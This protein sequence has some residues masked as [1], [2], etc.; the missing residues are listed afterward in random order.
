MMFPT[1]GLSGACLT[2]AFFALSHGK[3]YYLAP[4]YPMLLAAGAVCLGSVRSSSWKNLALAVVVV[5]GLLAAPITMPVRSP[6]K[7]TVYLD[8]LPFD[9]PRS[10]VSHRSAALPQYYADQFGWTE[11]AELVG[12]E[13]A[14]LPQ[15]D[16]QQCGIFAQNYGEAGALDFLGRRFHLPPVLSGHQSYFLW[17]AHNYSGKCLLVVGERREARLRELFE[18]VEFV[19][20]R[21]AN[22]ALESSIPVY[23]CRGP[24]FGTLQNIWPMLKR[25]S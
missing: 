15:D 10:E 23:L 12:R 14:R 8:R 6:E 20:V 11:L 22:Y 19:G 5:S 17:G 18:S 7:L 1:I 21:D 9:I 16:R 25:W 4:G 13:W 2:F 3:N 24:K